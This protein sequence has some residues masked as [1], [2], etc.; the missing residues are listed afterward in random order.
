KLAIAIA[1]LGDRTDQLK[2]DSWRLNLKTK[3]S[4][5]C[6]S[7]VINKLSLNDNERIRLTLYKTWREDRHQIRDLVDEKK[8]EIKID[9]IKEVSDESNKTGKNSIDERV[10]APLHSKPS[11]PLPEP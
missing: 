3:S 5:S 6:W 9:E 4:I 8:K 10:I 2:D 7:E 11:L 1:S